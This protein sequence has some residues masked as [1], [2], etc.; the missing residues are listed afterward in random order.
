M[1]ATK[2]KHRRSISTLCLGTVQLGMPYGIANVNGMPDEAAANKLILAAAQAGIT[3]FDTARAYGESETRLGKVIGGLQ[4]TVMTKLSPL[5]ELG[6]NSSAAALRNKVEESVYSSLRCLGLPRLPY[7]MLHRAHHL[8]AYDGKVWETLLELR[9]HGAIER[10]GV[11]AQNPQEVLDALR[12]TE[13]ECIQLPFN[14]LDR[15]YE[16]ANIPALLAA[17][18]EILVVA[19]SALLQ[20]LLTKEPSTWPVLREGAAKITQA[21]DAFVVQFGRKNRVDLCLAFVRAQPWIDSVVVGME[22]MRQLNDNLDLFSTEPLSPEACQ[23]LTQHFTYTD[24][25]LLNPACW[26]QKT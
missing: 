7:L 25:L 2:I 17:R 9:R 26:P 3:L 4:V 23:I 16:R 8:H 10:L 15:R 12:A 24:E 21:L 6:E 19:R 18:R 5:E 14:V 11:S 22:T 1:I 20:G 13:V